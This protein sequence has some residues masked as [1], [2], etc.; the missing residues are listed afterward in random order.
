MS[1]GGR[2]ATGL[3]AWPYAVVGP[4][5]THVVAGEAPADTVLEIVAWWVVTFEATGVSTVGTLEV[6]GVVCGGLS[7]GGGIAGGDAWSASR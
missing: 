3:V 1:C 5:S 2:A 4:Y 6:P 7:A